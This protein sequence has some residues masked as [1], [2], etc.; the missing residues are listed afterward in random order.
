MPRYRS[1]QRGEQVGTSK[2]L[3][4]LGAIFAI[5]FGILSIRLITFQ[6]GDDAKLEN[7]AL[8][9]YRT[10]VKRSTSRGKI[11]D[12]Q[13][14]DLAIDLF[15]ESIYANPMRVD[16]PVL[17]AEK[18]STL[19]GVD[20]RRLLERLGT[21]RKFVWVKRRAS[22]EEVDAVRKLGLGGVAMMK[23][24]KRYYPGKKLAS[25]VLGAVGFDS[26]PLG[27]VE[28]V[29]NKQ[30]SFGSSAGELRRDARGHLY[31][32]PADD[33]LD[34][35]SVG[36]TIDKTLQFIAERELTKAV[37]SSR[38]KAGTAIVVNV[39]SGAIL[40]MA[41]YPTFDPN[42][43]SSYPLSE[44]RNMAIVNSYE[45]GSTF[46]V[47]V[48][49]A[50]IDS[51]AV[52]ADD[53]F[54]CENGRIKIG[55]DVVRDAHPQSNT[56]VADIIKVSSNIG[57]YKIEKRLGR[58]RLYDSIRKFG[59]G[60]KTGLG[61]PGESMGILS[62]PEKWSPLQFATIAFGQGMAATP[63]QMTMSF[64]A[65]A[66]GGALL[67]PYIVASI[68]NSDGEEKVTTKRE[69]V[70]RPITEKT[71]TI[72]TGLLQR[73]VG[74]GGTG[75]LA[76]SYEYPMAGKTGTA[77]KASMSANGYKEGVYFSS[78]VGFAPADDP[79]I[80][81]FV[82]IDEPQGNYYYGGQVAAPAFKE[83]VEASLQYMKVPGS[84]TDLSDDVKSQ[85]PRL[86]V[87][88]AAP[89][90]EHNREMVAMDVKGRLKKRLER[91][92]DSSW[93]I[94]DL[95]GLTMRDIL[96]STGEADIR[97]EF[98]GSGI[99]VGQNP[100]AGSIMRDGEKC[101]VKFHTML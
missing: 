20:R 98:E 34:V 11:L 44:W 79:R 1:V 54:D 39:D 19:L 51:G 83:I 89:T 43:Y 61:L 29:Y 77:Q 50:A 56:S 101:T 47:I 12:S 76:S 28:L 69:V 65:I 22:K 57:A 15:V 8:R 3:F 6:L 18:L 2:R 85:L 4:A 88:D 41:N 31:L 13:G 26:K 40:A 23:E 71:A 14:R 80:A 94:P 37:R 9:Q 10:A 72:M 66:N 82:G 64:A 62:S 91:N 52:K 30:L 59:F 73:V 35:S 92:D 24:A 46:K 27:G 33:E 90:V 21:K 74:E 5:S 70:A 68:L 7:V 38:A 53:I 86:Q 45:P 93:R 32:S 87:V 36:L 25:S 63:L 81:V 84:G 95:K 42:D 100:A 97:W 99:A 48:V 55:E 16:E 60:K 75:T 96:K 49:A 67:K 58:K 17:V 78:F